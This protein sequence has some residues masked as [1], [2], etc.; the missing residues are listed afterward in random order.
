MNESNGKTKMRQDNAAYAGMVYAMDKSLGRIL[1]ALKDLKVDEN[2]IIVFFSDNGGLSNTGTEERLLATSNYP[3]RAGKGHLYEGGIRVPMIVKLPKQKNG[4]V[5]DAV[6]TGADFYPTLLELSNINLYPE[7][8]QDGGSF[9]WVLHNKKNPNPERPVFWHN[10]V[11]RPLRTGDYYNTAVIRGKYKLIDF[12]RQNRVELYDLSKDMKEENNL[13]V[14][15][16]DLTKE[17]HNLVKK[18][19]IDIDAYNQPIDKKTK[20]E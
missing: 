8:H 18:W 20:W 2:T 4:K 12:Y 3:L 5:S 16:P 15:L 10:G 13:A 11:A 7:Q 1:K 14:K 9:A 17:L 19:R 6:V